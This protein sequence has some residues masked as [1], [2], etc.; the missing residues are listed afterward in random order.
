MAANR[1]MR[2]IKPDSVVL[3]DRGYSNY[4]EF[5]DLA[6]GQGIDNLNFPSI[7]AGLAQTLTMT[8]P[9]AVVGKPVAVGTTIG[10]FSSQLI[11]SAFVSAT[12]TVTCRVFNP[13][14]GALDPPA[15]DW[16]VAVKI[17]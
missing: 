17:R 6:I 2:V 1:L 8:I 5:F 15:S 16:T 4:G 10:A 12:D 3:M 14:A 9:G 7:N 13:T 11:W